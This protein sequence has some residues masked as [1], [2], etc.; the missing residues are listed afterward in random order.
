MVRLC[1]ILPE[2]STANYAQS[3][4]TSISATSTTLAGRYKT[5]PGDFSHPVS[6]KNQAVEDAC[7]KRTLP[8]A[9]GVQLSLRTI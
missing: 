7:A 4:E 2:N 9:V 5:F 8:T 3:R 1:T 6:S